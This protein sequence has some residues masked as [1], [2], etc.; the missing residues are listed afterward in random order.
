MNREPKRDRSTSR[1][2]TVAAILLVAA[3]AGMTGVLIWIYRDGAIKIVN[4]EHW[5]AFIA[6][7]VVL[8]GAC[9]NVFVA[10]S[11]LFWFHRCPQ[12]GGRTMRVPGS[13]AVGS[14][15]RYD[16]AACNVEWDTGFTVAPP[17]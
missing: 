7:L 16:C 9:A 2:L 6:A 10:L 1:R 3:M 4:P 11:R 8:V 14:R 15:I 5:A 17:E 13:D 12:C